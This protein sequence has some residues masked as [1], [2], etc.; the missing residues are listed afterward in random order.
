ML[1]ERENVAI[2]ELAVYIIAIFFAI[3]IIFRHGLIKGRPW[4]YLV[5]FCGLRI[6]GAAFGILSANHPTSRSDATWSAILGSIGLSPLL[7]VASGL[8]KRV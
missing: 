7:L 8:L 6:A 3:A 4:I 2:A 1:S 5:V